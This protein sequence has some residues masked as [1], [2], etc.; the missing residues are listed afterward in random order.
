LRF[1]ECAALTE[2]GQP[3][4]DVTPWVDIRFPYAPSL[5]DR[6]DLSSVPVERDDGLRGQLIAETYTYDH[7]GTI[8]VE[9]ENRTHGYRRRFVLGALG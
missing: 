5:A 3:T 2:D 7:S 4:G 8:T 9:L 6:G 1:L